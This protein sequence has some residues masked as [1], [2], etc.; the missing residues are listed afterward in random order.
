MRREIPWDLIISKLKQTQTADEDQQLER[1]LSDGNHREVF[2]ELQQVWQKTQAKASGYT[3]DASHYW[4]ELS[5]RMQATKKP[6]ASAV[7]TFSLLHLRRYAAVACVLL[8]AAFSLCV[9]IGIELGQPQQRE[10][11]YT[12]WGGKSLVSLPDGSRVWLH[13]VTSLAY[14]TDFESEDRQVNVTGEAYFEVAPNKR[15]PFVVQTDGMK[16]IVHGTKFNVESFPESE[17]TFVSL[18]EGSVSLETNAEKRFL[19]PGETATFN[20]KSHSLHIE[21]GDVEFSR[22]WADNQMVF[23]RKSLGYV[24]R[25]LSKWYNVNIDLAPEL[26]DKYMYTFTLRDEPLEEILRLMSRINP[27]EYR[28]NEKNLL[29]ILPKK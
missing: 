26:A 2:E 19:V 3:P 20:K 18:I 13:T 27:I 7:K 6:Q 12:N 16:I 22:S 28:F 23:N 14:N 1:W 17:N 9:Y 25:F 24:C 29:I 4:K 8:I 21:K 15:K 11:T 5:Q 10:Q